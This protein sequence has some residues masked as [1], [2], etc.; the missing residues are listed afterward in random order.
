MFRSLFCI[1]LLAASVSTTQAETVWAR[2]VSEKG[3]WVDINKAVTP[4]GKAWANPTEGGMCYAAGAANLIVW[5]QAQYSNIPANAPNTQ[6][7]VWRTYV[8]YANHGGGQA[9][10][11]LQWWFS[12]SYN[13]P[14]FSPK[15]TLLNPRQELYFNQ[16]AVNTTLDQFIC[17]KG[18]TSLVEMAKAEGGLSTGLVNAFK[19]GKGLAIGLSGISHTV[20]LWG[21]EVDAAT[22]TITKLWLTDSDDIR[23]DLGNYTAPALFSVSVKPRKARINNQPIVTLQIT[24]NDGNRG[25]KNAYITALYG[26]DPAVTNAPIWGLQAR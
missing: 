6:E 15:N 1:A 12:G 7:S 8:Q 3:G 19:E 9:S 24:G 10:C 20:T 14:V 5:W 26:V 25:F 22:Q 2:G 13:S 4:D 21:V 11:A 23:A 16:E 18:G 17:F